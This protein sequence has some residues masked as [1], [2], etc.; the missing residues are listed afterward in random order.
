VQT[1]SG[2]ITISLTALSGGGGCSIDG[3]GGAQILCNGTVVSSGLLDDAGAEEA[4]SWAR[5]GAG[6][7]VTVPTG[8]LTSETL[9]CFPGGAASSS[10]SSSS[11][12]TEFDG[13]FLQIDG[14]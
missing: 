5:L 8:V 12:G 14:G 11:G 13:G 3:S 6:F 7:T 10:S 1:I 4:V 9:T 2:S